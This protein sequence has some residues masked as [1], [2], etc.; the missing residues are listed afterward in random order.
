MQKFFNNSHQINNFMIDKWGSKIEIERRRRIMIS[1]WAYA[2]EFE[3]ETLVSD[4][5]FDDECMKVDESVSTGNKKLD[6][7]FKEKF[8][9][10]TGIWI[11]KHPELDGIKKL[12]E[13][14]Y[15]L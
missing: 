12:Y 2:Y 1:I 5:E 13:K 15:K 14:Y 11:H 6:K 4:K 3:N 8:D 7:F 10:F 9:P